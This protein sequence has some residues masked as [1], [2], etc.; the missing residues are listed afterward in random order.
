M[1]DWDW[2]T[3]PVVEWLVFG[4]GAVSGPAEFTERLLLEQQVAMVPGDAFGA[5]GAGHVRACYATS[6]ANIEEA[7]ERTRRFVVS[8]G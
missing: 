7:L 4:S 5:C 8:L 6:M 1:A 3:D 2:R